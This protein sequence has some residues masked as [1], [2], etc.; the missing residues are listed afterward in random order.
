MNTDETVGREEFEKLLRFKMSPDNLKLVMKAYRMSKYGHRGQ[1]RDSGER[2]FE[3]PKTVALII[4]GEFKIYDHEVI[5][6]A[7]LHD[8]VEDSFIFGNNE[9]AFE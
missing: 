4:A 9:E 7:L 1:K 6:A 2:Y 8:D 5:S 3:H